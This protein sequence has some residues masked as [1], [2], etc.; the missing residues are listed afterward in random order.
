MPVPPLARV[1]LGAPAAASCP[2][3]PARHLK[4]VMSLWAAA[5]AAA[6]LGQSLPAS[7]APVVVC[8]P[9]ACSS[10]KAGGFCW[11]PA[12]QAHRCHFV[13]DGG[14]ACSMQIVWMCADA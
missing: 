14:F 4:M 13:P 7:P 10:C 1:V 12:G 2:V 6:L 5:M 3:A 8:L 11:R 9:A